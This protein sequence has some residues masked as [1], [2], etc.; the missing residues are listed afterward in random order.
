MGS[1]L[2]LGAASFNISLSLTTRQLQA[3]V[4]HEVFFFFFYLIWL[5]RFV[6]NLVIL[7]WI[8]PSV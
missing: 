4:L 8:P 1:V 6:S 3:Y 2:R 7:A 5:C